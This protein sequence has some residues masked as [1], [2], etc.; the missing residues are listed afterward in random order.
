MGYPLRFDSRRF[1]IFNHKPAR[2]SM[3]DRKSMFV[4]SR[5]GSLA[6]ASPVPQPAFVST[7][8]YPALS[9]VGLL[10]YTMPVAVLAIGAPNSTKSLKWP[11]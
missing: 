6:I 11:A 5:L 8:F 1:L 4:G 2:I 3:G 10:T 9:G 7:L